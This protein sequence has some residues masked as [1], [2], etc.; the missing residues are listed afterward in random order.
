ML[1]SYKVLFSVIKA[2]LTGATVDPEEFRGMDV[3]YQKL[4]KLSVKHQITP[5]VFQGLYAITGEFEGIEKYYDYTFSLMCHDQAQ[6]NYLQQIQKVFTDG[7]IDYM[8]LKGSSIKPL[9]PSP[10]MRVMGDMDILIKEEQYPQIQKLMPQTGLHEEYESNHELVWKNDDG[11]LVELHKKLIPSYNDDYYAYYSAPWE[12]AVLQEG[13][14]YAMTAE[15]EYIYIFTHMTK[16]YRDG[17]IGLR[18]IIDIWFYRLCH[19]EMDMQYI[20]AELDKVGLRKFHENITATTRVWFDGEP[21]TPLS[22]YITERIIESG[23]YG[24]KEKCE[25]AG[26]ARLSAQDT[27][28]SAAQRHRLLWLIFLPY[29][30]MKTKYPVLERAPVLLPLM[31]VVRWVQALTTKKGNL[32][33]HMESVKKINA[34]TVDAYTKELEAVGLQFDLKKR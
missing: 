8:L 5:M 27:S 20:Y 28:T 9:Y 15:D 22:A 31:W 21:E 26:A 11:I 3:D 1:D 6:R 10:E 7:D 33:S 17:G 34:E 2:T 25:M 29:D 30:G 12:K 4:L 24:L 23:A 14:R 16:H 19:P 18:H 13:S 32:S